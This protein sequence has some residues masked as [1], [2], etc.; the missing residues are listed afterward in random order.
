MVTKV[1]QLNS[2]TVG[3]THFTREEKKL[4]V[5]ASARLMPTHDD[6]RGLHKLEKCLHILA[7]Q[8]LKQTKEQRLTV[9]TFLIAPN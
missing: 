2:V 3:I 5:S 9:A 4:A 1:W 7:L 6:F 8:H